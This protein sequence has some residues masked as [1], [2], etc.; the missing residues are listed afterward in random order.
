MSQSLRAKQTAA[1][2]WKVLAAFKSTVLIVLA[3]TL[4]SAG[5]ASAQEAAAEPRLRKMEAE[6]RALQRNV[7]P[8]GGGQMFSPEIRNP[9][10]R[11]VA[12]GRP[13]TTPATD[14]RLRLQSIESALTGL[15]ARLQQNEDRLSRIEKNWAQRVA[16]A[17]PGTALPAVQASAATQ[18]T[19][20]AVAA[21]KEPTITAPSAQ[22]LAAFR[23]II[24]PLTN[25]PGDDEY[26]YGFRLWQA[27]LYPEAEQQLKMFIA[28]YAHHARISYARN[29]LGR[30]YLDEGKPMEAAKWFLANYK[31]GRTDPRAPDSLLYL[32]EAMLRLKDD[33][34][35]CVALSE[36]REVYAAGH[37]M[38][39]KS[40][41]DS[42]SAKSKCR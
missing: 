19:V 41:Y 36:F 5:Q 42:I 26:S 31:G 23:A 27:S 2:G 32:S 17:Q 15:T 10:S 7:F 39:L 29:L 11:S 9:P 35:A 4:I 20:P 3:S 18:G 1:A 30:A 25:D 22:R 21:A 28:K 12:A 6:I 37:F 13:A 33:K 14:L 8:G 16:A 34:R 38:R 24:K 40:L